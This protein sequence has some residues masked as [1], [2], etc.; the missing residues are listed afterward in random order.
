V[1]SISK[2]RDSNHINFW[3]V[4]LYTLVDGYFGGKLCVQFKGY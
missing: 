2:D 3:N 1:I 4:A